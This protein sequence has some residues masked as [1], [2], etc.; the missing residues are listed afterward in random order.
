[1]PY[2]PLRSETRV[3]APGRT[4]DAGVVRE[5]HHRHGDGIE[6]ADAVEPHLEAVRAERDVGL[7]LVSECRAACR[8]DGD[9]PLVLGGRVEPRRIG[10]QDKYGIDSGG[11]SV[12]G[13]LGDVRARE[14]QSEPPDVR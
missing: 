7:G 3:A 4:T 8:F 12:A 2:R 9:V 14:R 13:V 5:S 10:M 6:Y 11:T 1:E